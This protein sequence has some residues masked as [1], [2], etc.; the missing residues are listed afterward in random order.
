MQDDSDRD[1]PADALKW[2]L[3]SVLFSTQPLSSTL[4]RIL[5]DTAWELYRTDQGSSKITAPLVQGRLENLRKD[6]LLG[7]VGGPAFEATVDTERGT[8]TVRFI[9]TRQGLEYMAEQIP[10]TSRN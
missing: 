6:M 10:D 4:A 7:T 9:I 8:G 5:F 1:D 2:R 3:I